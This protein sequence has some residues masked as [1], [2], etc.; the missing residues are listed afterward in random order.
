MPGGSLCASTDPLLHN[1]VMAAVGG[2]RAFTEDARIAVRPSREIAP[3]DARPIQKNPAFA[4]KTRRRASRKAGP[5]G[6]P[7]QAEN[8]PGRAARTRSR[9]LALQL[10]SGLRR[11]I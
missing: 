1:K 8:F 10:H 6:G 5:K 3:D 7:S 4:C 9:R 11:H 2:C